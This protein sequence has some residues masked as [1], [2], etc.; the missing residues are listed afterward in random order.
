MSC[1]AIVIQISLVAC[2][3]DGRLQ[4]AFSSLL[5]ELFPASRSAK[6]QL[7]CPVRK[8]SIMD[9]RRPHARQLGYGV[10]LR[11]WATQERMQS[12]LGFMATINLPWPWL[13]IQSSTNVRS[14]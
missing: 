7:R 10:F 8:R 5:E 13:R 6:L 14:T 11:N 3:H 1:M 4:G 9:W 2:T 12:A